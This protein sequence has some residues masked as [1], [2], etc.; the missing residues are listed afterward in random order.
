VA[1]NYQ[2]G[3][4]LEYRVREQLTTVGYLVVRASASKGIA[5]LVAIAKDRT[6][7]VSCK[8]GKGGAP[9]A[10]RRQLGWVA[11]ERAVWAVLAWQR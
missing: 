10:E 6:L 8:L 9:P 3:R 4:G 11:A 2:R 5:D 1:S 7:L